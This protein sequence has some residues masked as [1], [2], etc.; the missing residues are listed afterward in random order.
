MDEIELTAIIEQTDIEVK[1][2]VL[3]DFYFYS[4]EDD[5]LYED[6]DEYLIDMKRT[7]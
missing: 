5:F 2:Q 4:T 1:S 3:E 7:Y 6:D